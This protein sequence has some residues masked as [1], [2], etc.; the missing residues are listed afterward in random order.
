M[1]LRES[2][3]RAGFQVALEA[4]R[5]FFGRELGD[6]HQGPRAVLGGVPAGSVIVP[7]QPI[8]NVARHADVVTVGVDI[9]SQDVDE[10]LSDSL[11]GARECTARATMPLFVLPGNSCIG[12]EYE[13]TVR[14]TCDPVLRRMWRKLPVG[15]FAVPED[16]GSVPVRIRSGGP[17]PR[18]CRYGETA[19]ARSRVRWC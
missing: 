3:A 15:G 9:A 16:S 17:P 13:R 5:L 19:F 8:V 12:S 7:R 10:A 6:D 1:S 2:P 4:Q 18:L 11:H 14:R